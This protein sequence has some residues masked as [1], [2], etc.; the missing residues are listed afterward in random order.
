MYTPKMQEIPEKSL[1]DLDYFDIVYC[2]IFNTNL[3][4]VSPHLE[5]QFGVYIRPKPN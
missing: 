2:H 4:Q 1:F 3:L 5:K